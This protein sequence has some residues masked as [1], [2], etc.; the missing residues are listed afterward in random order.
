MKDPYFYEEVGVLKNLE[1]I[2]VDK[3]LELFENRMS[4]LGILKLIK[5]SPKIRDIYSIKEIHHVLFEK[6]YAWA[7][8]Y[9]TINIYKHEPILDGLSVP[10]SVA[11]NINQDLMKLNEV[12]L[13]QNWLGLSRKSMA[14]QLTLIVSKLWKIHPFREGNTR[15]VATFTYLL[16]KQYGISF[17]FDIISNHAK[18]FRNALVMASLDESPEIHYLE[19]MLFDSMNIKTIASNIS[20][21]KKI[22][23]YEVETYEYD[24]HYTE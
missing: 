18:Y 13:K 17:N 3:E 12:L 1:H 14:T 24:Y 8:E 22:K 7:G 19:N 6:V 4:T 15:A 2:K 21:Y 11:K 23:D 9:R 5:E 16:L 20:K 10:Y